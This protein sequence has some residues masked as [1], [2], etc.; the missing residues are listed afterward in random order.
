MTERLETERQNVGPGWQSIITQL[1]TDLQKVVPGYSV[2]QIKEKFGGL[3]FYI[4]MTNG[5]APEQ[6]REAWDIVYTAESE[7]FKTCEECGTK[8]DVTTEGPR[9][10]RTLCPPCRAEVARKVAEEW[11]SLNE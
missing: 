1:D 4:A 7:T 2:V 5:Y 9:W 8:E 6:M 3:R 11:A 10:I